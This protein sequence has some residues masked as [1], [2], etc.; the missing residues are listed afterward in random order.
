MIRV[1]SLSGG[2]G[3]RMIVEDVSFTA[4]KGE[5]V[6]ILGPNGSGKTTL[7]K[8]LTGMLSPSKGEVLVAGRPAGRYK[9]RELAKIMAVLPQH[10]EQAFTFTVKETVSFGRYPYQ[11]GLF[12]QMDQHDEDIVREAMEMTGIDRYAQQSVRNLSGGERQRVY[13]AQA[14]AQQPEVLCLDEPTTFL[15]LKY[16]K[17][18]LDTVKRLTRERGLT[19]ISIFHDFNAASQYCDQLLM[20]KDGRAFPKQ[21]PDQALKKETI[22]DIYGITVSA[23][24]RQSSPKPLIAFMPEAREEREPAGVP[25]ASLINKSGNTV[26][27]HTERPFRMLSTASDGPG[28]SWSRRLSG[29]AAAGLICRTFDSVTIAVTAQYTVW[30]LISGRL[31]EQGFVRLLTAA[32]EARMQALSGRLAK[33]DIAICALQTGEAMDVPHAERAVRRG[34]AVCVKAAEEGGIQQ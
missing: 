13:L 11:K 6:G 25:F 2:Y 1:S 24:A 12:R 30:V 5:F 14:L 23:V 8:L 31:S 10:T 3:G 15:D 26:T 20:M 32:A 18:L 29:S 34:T 19:V 22:E 28:F 17:D 33:G 16:Q 7:M 9:P 21:P 27:L 4:G